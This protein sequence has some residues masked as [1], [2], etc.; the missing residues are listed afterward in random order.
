MKQRA[1]DL[2]A[3]NTKL[4]QIIK[5]NAKRKADNVNLSAE[6]T[7][8]KAENVK[9]KQAMREN[10]KHRVENAKLKA[11]SLQEIKMR[12]RVEKTMLDLDRRLRSGAIHLSPEAISD[13]AS[14]ELISA[15]IL[16][17]SAMRFCTT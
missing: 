16:P 6:N 10:A 12:E 15:L 3:E 7:K 9:L 8:V 2:E 11:E 1:I 14:R 17:I 13:I 5:E 4:K